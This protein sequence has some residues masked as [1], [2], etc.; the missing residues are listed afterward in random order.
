MN[1]KIKSLTAIIAAIKYDDFLDITLFENKGIFDHTVVITDSK[2]IKTQE[3]C[4]KHKVTCLVT[5]VFYINNNKFNRGMAYNLAF[6]H[7]KKTLDW[8]LL[9]DADIVVPKDFEKLFF[10]GKPDINSMYGCRRYDIQEYS[11][12]EKIKENK[13]LL[14]NHRLFRGVGYGYFQLFNFKSNIIKQLSINDNV[15]IYPPFPTVSEGDWVFRNYWSDW[16]FDPPLNDDP[17]QHNIENK[18]RPKNPI[19]LKQLPFNVIHLGEAGKNG[20]SRITKHF[21]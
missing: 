19:L 17:N 4:K 18:D 1:N 2:D 5:D 13:E 9:L 16:I 6:E 20:E 10:D 8:V 11:D 3:L 7:L 15:I 14:K 21:K 12:W